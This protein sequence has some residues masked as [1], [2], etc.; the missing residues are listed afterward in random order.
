MA[1]TSKILTMHKIITEFTR[2]RINFLKKTIDELTRRIEAAPEGK[3]RIAEKGTRTEY[4]QRLSPSERTG[5]YIR[6]SDSDTI[7]ALAQKEYDKHALKRAKKE[8]DLCLRIIDFYPN[9]TIEST[10]SDI[11]DKITELVAPYYLPDNE[12]FEWWLDRPARFL[13]LKEDSKRF[14]SAS[15]IRT[16]SKS[17]HILATDLKDFGLPF[18]YERGLFL[19][20]TEKWVYPDFTLLDPETREEIYWEH[21]GMMDDPK[22]ANK[23]IEKLN[24]YEINGFHLGHQ[25]IATFESSDHPLDIELVEGIISDIAHGKWTAR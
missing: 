6:K 24:E 19:P 14:G 12:F 9:G 20:L 13:K 2:S 5:R 21:F 8:L 4:Y 10:A 18:L 16:R 1:A 7:T 11:S 25:L 17:E 22:Y 15:S 23:A 3:L